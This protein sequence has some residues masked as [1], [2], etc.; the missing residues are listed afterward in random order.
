MFDVICL[1]SSTVDVFAKTRY[2]EL[3]KIVDSKGEKDLLAYPTGSKIL[4]EE[5][6]FTTGGGGTNVAASLS[7][8]GVKTAYLGCLGNDSNAHFILD[9]L[10]RF[11][12]DPSLIVRKKGQTGYS[13]ILDSLEH[14]R[15]ILAHKG[16]NN[17]L[18]FADF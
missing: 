2:S 11:K 7:S 13:I 18:R 12:I 3:I 4:I 15:T 14:D 16:V 10:K 9:A 8:L 1:G 6:D 5:L 17:D